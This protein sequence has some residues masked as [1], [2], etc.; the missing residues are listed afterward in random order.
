MINELME[1]SMPYSI[2]DL[3]RLNTKELY[4]KLIEKYGNEDN[5][6]DTIIPTFQDF[7]KKSPGKIF[8]P[9]SSI[10]NLRSQKT[11]LLPATFPLQKSPMNCTILPFMSFPELSKISSA[12]LL[13]I[14]GNF[15]S[16]KGDNINSFIF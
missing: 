6:S 3:K 2:S 15:L 12:C 16:R 10:K 8:L 13:P 1:V 5:F 4:H 9:I 11:C 14:T 7:S